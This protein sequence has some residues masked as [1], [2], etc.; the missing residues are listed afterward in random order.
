MGLG[1][2]KLLL[3]SCM[4]LSV[5]GAIAQD[6][7]APKQNPAKPT[8]H[9][10]PK[11]VCFP[12]DEKIEIDED[13]KVTVQA[14]SG[15]YDSAPDAI[16]AC[17]KAWEAEHTQELNRRVLAKIRGACSD[18]RKIDLECNQETKSEEKSKCRAID[19]SGFDSSKAKTKPPTCTA[20]QN[21][22]TG[23]IRWSVEGGE[24]TYKGTVYVLC[25]P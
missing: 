2:G 9:V 24:F 18:S 6:Q 8:Y 3:S 20:K 22:D 5:L 25:D 21:A 10:E 23:K 7:P 11:C 19:Y 16:N 4:F 1:Y 13:V 15:D 17:K 14:G 12:A